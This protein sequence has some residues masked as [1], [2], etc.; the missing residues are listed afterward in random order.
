MA[1]NPISIG[2][3]Q[4]TLQ[5]ALA[6]VR[7]AMPIAQAAHAVLGEGQ[8]AQ[9]AAPSVGANML[10]AGPQPQMLGSVQ[11]LVAL[12]A[13]NPQEL[14]RREHIQHARRGLDALERL[15]RELIEGPAGRQTLDAL[16]D[17][18]RDENVSAQM[19]PDDPRFTGLMDE[20]EL[21]VRVE[22]AKFNIEI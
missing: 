6:L 16:A 22:L 11:M 7:E 8:G 3:P 5:Q 9:S 4:A 21:R 13:L 20:I 14:R 10:Q 12:S 1:I 15:H 18:L 2:T 17:W 19:L